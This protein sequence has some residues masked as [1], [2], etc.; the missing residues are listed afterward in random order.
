[1]TDAKQNSIKE[2]LEVSAS[3]LEYAEYETDVDDLLHIEK[4]AA[5]LA[6]LVQEFHKED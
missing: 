1:M 4:L 6:R 2:Q 5:R 3:I